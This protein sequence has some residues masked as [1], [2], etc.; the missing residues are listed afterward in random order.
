MNG[1]ALVAPWCHW[2]ELSAGRTAGV[3]SGDVTAV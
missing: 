3:G 2:R 1:G